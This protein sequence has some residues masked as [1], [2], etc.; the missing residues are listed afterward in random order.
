MN[1]RR[2]LVAGRPARRRRWST[3]DE[4]QP[5]TRA[6]EVGEHGT[7]REPG[8]PG[9]RRRPRRAATSDRPGSS[10]R[11][12][13]EPVD[14]A[15]AC[16]SRS[17]PGP[18]DRR[19]RAPRRTRGPARSS[20]QPRC[21]SSVAGSS[22]HSRT[23]LGQPQ[24]VL[25]EDQAAT[26][27]ADDRRRRRRSDVRAPG[28]SRAMQPPGPQV[29]ALDRAPAPARPAWCRRTRPGRPCRRRP[30][31]MPCGTSQRSAP[32]AQTPAHMAWSLAKR[33]SDLGPY[34]GARPRT[35][36]YVTGPQVSVCALV[37]SVSGSGAGSARVGAAGEGEHDDAAIAW[38]HARRPVA[39]RPDLPTHTQRTR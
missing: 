34:D 8:S 28:R 2:C 13:V 20:A 18:A 23:G 7:L 10:T 11:S 29:D 16:A 26:V 24:A 12:R 31:A 33:P 1:P 15:R 3:A 25:V 21:T 14:A 38:R 39:R 4:P 17:S 32:G 5:R 9:R 27:P 22:S 37:V 6:V 19:R 36:A 30:T 35:S